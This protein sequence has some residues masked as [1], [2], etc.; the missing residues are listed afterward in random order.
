MSSQDLS[1]DNLSIDLIPLNVVIYHKQN[2]AFIIA[3]ANTALLKSECVDKNELLGRV[4]KSPFSN[5][6]D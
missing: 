3:N 1:Y 6:Y 4:L 5:A 2:N